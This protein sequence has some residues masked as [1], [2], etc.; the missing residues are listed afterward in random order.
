MA[1]ERLYADH[2]ANDRSIDVL[3]TGRTET[4]RTVDRLVDAAVRAKGQAEPRRI[5]LAHHLVEAF[6]RVAQHMQHR[7]EHLARQLVDRA[8]LDEGRWHEQ[9]G[10]CRGRQFGL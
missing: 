7:T 8:D 1:A 2:G 6:A 4:D 5:R 9:T 3:V 10:A